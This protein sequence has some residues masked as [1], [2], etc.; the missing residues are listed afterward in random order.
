MRSKFNFR[1]GAMGIVAASICTLAFASPTSANPNPGPA[2]ASAAESDSL[3][4]GNAANDSVEKFDATTGADLGTFVQPGSGG[5]HGPRGLLFKDNLLVSNQNV[6]QSFNGEIDEYSHVDGNFLGAI[7]P[8][9]DA[10]APFN[11]DGIIRGPDNRTLYVADLQICDRL[12]CNGRVARYDISNGKFLGNLDFSRFIRNPALNPGGEFHPRGLVFGPDGLLYVSLRSLQDPTLGW[13]LSYNTGTGAI[14]VLASNSGAGCSARLHRPDGL[15][16]GPDGKLYV[17]SFRADPTD[18]DRI[19]VFKGRVCVDEVALDEVGQARA[20]AQYI[21][22]GPRGFLFVPI[23]GEV[24]NAGAVRKYDVRTKA[25]TNF[26]APGGDS[27]TNS[28]WGLTFGGT[29]PT[30]LTYRKS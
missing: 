3:Y 11:P 23:T 7:V 6:G 15:T 29:N 28:W 2:D 22:F 9:T 1:R 18:I 4:V 25:F 16:F 19:L 30:T 13:I 10:N 14:K 26:V 8:H 5:L 27:G 20:F 21:L 17:T 12:D 24:P